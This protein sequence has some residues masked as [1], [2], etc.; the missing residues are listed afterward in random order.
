MKIIP[1]SQGRF[2]KIDDEDFERVSQFKWCTTKAGDCFYARRTVNKSPSCEKSHSI[3]LHRF[4]LKIEDKSIIVDH[5]DHDTLN[6]Q[7]YNL[8]VCTKS[9]NNRNKLSAKNSSSRFLGVT[10]RTITV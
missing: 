8:R 7:K 2:A 10:K 4:I 3:L 5:N 1:L 6:C 9:E